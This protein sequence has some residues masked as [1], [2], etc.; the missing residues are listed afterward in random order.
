VTAVVLVE[1]QRPANVGAAARAMKNFGLHDLRLVGARHCLPGGDGHREARALAWNAADVLEGA[2]PFATL[3]EA[4]ADLHFVA[5]T[6]GREDVSGEVMTP[7]AF[8]AEIASLPAGSRAGLVFG[9]E[10]HGLTNRELSCCRAR[11]HIQTMGDQPSLNLAQA[12]V[13]MAYEMALAAPASHAPVEAPEPA[14][15]GDI[16][17]LFTAARDL[18]LR[19]G[20]L[21]ARA[22]EHVLSELRSLLARARPTSREI[23]LLQGLVA[24]LRWATEHAERR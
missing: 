10:D 20:F 19:S 23:E 22:P 18:G 9:R 8:A 21:N 24:Q 11:V 3:E 14:R 4:V 16:E 6:T 15:E 7:R 2:A 17:R 1:P 12:V 5:A 13:V